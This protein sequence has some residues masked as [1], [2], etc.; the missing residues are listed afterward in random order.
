MS[1]EI[2]IQSLVDATLHAA[3]TSSRVE[4]MKQEEKT[5]L[6]I[7]E[8]L[9]GHWDHGEGRQI[10]IVAALKGMH[11]RLTKDVGCLSTTFL[12]YHFLVKHYDKRPEAVDWTHL[13]RDAQT[14]RDLWDY[15]L[16]VNGMEISG[17]QILQAYDHSFFQ[18]LLGTPISEFKAF[19]LNAI[20]CD[21]AVPI[22]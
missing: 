6:E 4:V 16:R 22:N 3:S 7:S 12:G 18:D 14:L 21:F 11:D 5:P 13:M 15:F 8:S 17:V 20:E 1:N 2:N 10:L 19:G 9:I